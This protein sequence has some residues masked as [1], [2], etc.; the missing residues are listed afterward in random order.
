MRTTYR[1]IHCDTGVTS[2]RYCNPEPLNEKKIWCR[3]CKK[4]T[5]WK[6]VH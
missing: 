1:C 2:L 6:L 3:K 4:T 5:T